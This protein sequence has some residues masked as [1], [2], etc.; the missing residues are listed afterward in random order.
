MLNKIYGEKVSLTVYD[1]DE[2]IV[3]GTEVRITIKL[4]E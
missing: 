3:S 4:E 1:L 2:G